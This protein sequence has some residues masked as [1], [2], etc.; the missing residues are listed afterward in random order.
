MDEE[1]LA[2][3]IEIAADD[4]TA[5]VALGLIHRASAEQAA[6]YDLADGSSD[7]NP[8]GVQVPRSVFLV[9]RLD[10]RPVGCGALRPMS[11][12][13]FEDSAEV[14][15]IY[16]LPEARGRR[17]GGLILA[18][19]EALARDFGYAR[20]VLETGDLQPQA[21]RLYERAGYARIPNYG[22][23]VGFANSLC[24]AKP[25]ASLPPT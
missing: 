25:L 24:F 1:R 11:E 21:I 23:Y 20:V 10:G 17:I 6:L 22:P 13:G 15:R 16:L 14:K 9:A 4:P 7:F 5:P 18:R 3:R 12:P 2:E 8:A 19:L